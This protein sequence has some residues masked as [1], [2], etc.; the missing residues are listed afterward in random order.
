MATVYVRKNEDLEAAL[1][2]FKRYTKKDG[3]L[4]D[5]RKQQSFMSETERQRAKLKERELRQRNKKKHR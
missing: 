1:E 4:N 3:T 2:R 5:Y